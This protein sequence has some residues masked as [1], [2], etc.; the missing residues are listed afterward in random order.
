MPA[1]VK[2]PA[3]PPLQEVDRLAP[4]QQPAYLPG[5]LQMLCRSCNRSKQQLCQPDL[6]RVGEDRARELAAALDGCGD[7]GAAFAALSAEVLVKL[8]AGLERRITA[9]K[10]DALAAGRFTAQQLTDAETRLRLLRSNVAAYNDVPRSDD[11]CKSVHC[12]FSPEEVAAVVS[13][14]Q[15]A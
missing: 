11:G 6:G 15:C 10:V 2:A 3:L 7:G 4:L 12:D 9:G 14:Q 8:A 13:Q 5:T 1:T